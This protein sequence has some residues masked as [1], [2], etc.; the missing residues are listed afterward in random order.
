MIYTINFNPAVDYYLSFKSFKEGELNSPITDYKL[1]GGKGINVS[2]V[3]KNYSVESTCL[4]FIGGFTGKFIDDKLKEYGI[5]SNF[6]NIDSDTRINIKINNDGI[7]TEVAGIAPEI[8]SRDYDNL[9][10]K[11]V[12]NIQSGDILVLSGSVPKS[13]SSDSYAK[14]IEVLPKDVKVILDTRGSA[15]D[16]ALKKGVFLIKPNRDELKEYFN[17]EFHSIDDII[18]GGQELQSLGAENVIISMGKNGSVFITR[19][20]IYIGNVPK[21]TLISSVGAGDS[22]VA[23]FI[24]GISKNFSIENAYKFSIAS[25]SATAFSKGLATLETA[26]TL[27]NDIV[28]KKVEVNK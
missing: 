5:F 18:R 24:Y 10:A 14:I 16:S 26:N 2:K 23:G 25:G 7:E 27:L 4:G 9:L 13:M 20:E 15:F 12:D 6:I 19:D 3:L 21:G 1:P 17:R 28:I 11:I 22:M 8:S